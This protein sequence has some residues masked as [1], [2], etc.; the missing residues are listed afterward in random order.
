MRIIAGK[1]GRRIIKSPASDK[2]RPTSDRLRETLFNIITP[3]ITEN[4]KFLDL[5]SGTGAVGIEALSRGASFAT[6][7]DKSR[8]ACI[9]IEENLDLLGVPENETEVVQ[10]DAAEYLKRANKKFDIIFYDPPYSSDYNYVLWVVSE[11]EVLSESGVFI[12][13]HDSKKELPDVVG[14]LRRW[15]KLKQGS[16]SL[17]FYEK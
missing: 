5:C 8:R 6:F 13:E 7:V 1:Y 14:K 17:S 4:T 10:A 3:R 16:S 11:S 15:R 9:L 12:A 2:V